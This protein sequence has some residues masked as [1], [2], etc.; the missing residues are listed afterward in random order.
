M[1]PRSD[2]PEP[3]S[4]PLS[5]FAG[6]RQAKRVSGIWKLMLPQSALEKQTE[7]QKGAWGTPPVKA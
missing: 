1:A 3:H 2:D 4:E 7:L 5:V 6:R